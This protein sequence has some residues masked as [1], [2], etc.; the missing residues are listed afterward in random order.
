ML[1][2]IEAAFAEY[3]KL[4]AKPARD[5]SSYG[6]IYVN[7]KQDLVAVRNAARSRNT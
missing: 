1:E 7:S 2:D 6:L 5:G 4:I 3:G